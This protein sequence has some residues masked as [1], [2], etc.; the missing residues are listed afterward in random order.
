[1]KI[2]YSKI[3]KDA[4]KRGGWSGGKPD[5]STKWGDIYR[6]LAERLTTNETV[7]DIGTAEGKRFLSLAP[8]IKKG[9]GIDIEPEMIGLARR[10]GKP[11][12]N[13][14]FRVMNAHKL[15]FP[16]NVFDVILA[17]H[18]PINLKEAAKVLKSG[19]VIITQQ[20]HELD[21]LNIK[22]FFRRGQGFGIKAGTLMK[23]YISEAKNNNL[24]ITKKLVSN[25]PYYFKDQTELV[26]YLKRTPTIP[27]FGSKQDFIKL[28]VF[29]K[30]N[31]TTKGIRTNTARF[32]LELSKPIR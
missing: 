32:L 22:R 6:N 13:M 12:K 16:Q 5:A 20:V 8:R 19:G 26:K 25:Q 7:L 2:D 23:R 1:M 27:D 15:R 14:D 30:Q 28:K 4:A 17:R 11:F 21:K 9:I 10:N 24:K 29:V 31:K 3:Y 18:A